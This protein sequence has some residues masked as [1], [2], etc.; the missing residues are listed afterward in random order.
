MAGQGRSQSWPVEQ[1]RHNDLGFR[2]WQLKRPSN[3]GFEFDPSNGSNEHLSHH[4]ALERNH[5]PLRQKQI[6]DKGFSGLIC[7]EER[8]DHLFRR[9]DKIF[10]I[11]PELLSA[12]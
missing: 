9:R 12:A 8:L 11:D 3:G 10:T 2:E 7:S 4:Q 6:V 1:L 5:T